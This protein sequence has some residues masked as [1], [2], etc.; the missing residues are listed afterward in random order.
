MTPKFSLHES[1]HLSKSG[2]LLLLVKR[3]KKHTLVEHAKT[4]P[5]ETLESKL[6]KSVDTFSLHEPLLL[7]EGKWLLGST[8]SE[9]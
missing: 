2:E 7:K 4:R 5:Q 8:S 1:P 3:K 9:L 6:T